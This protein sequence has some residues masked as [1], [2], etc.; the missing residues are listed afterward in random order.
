MRC[1][2]VQV[3]E[4]FPKENNQNGVQDYQRSDSGSHGLHGIL[5][6]CAFGGHHTGAS[7]LRAGSW[8]YR[9]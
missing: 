8:C 3:P 7:S 1:T 2:E 6:R 9:V 4:S 5:T